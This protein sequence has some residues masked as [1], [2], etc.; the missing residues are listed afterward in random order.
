MPRQ[1]GL[2]VFRGLLDHLATLTRNQI[3]YHG[4]NIE[5][6]KLADPTP[7]SAARSTYSIARSPS[8]SPRSQNNLPPKP[9]NPQVNPRILL[10]H[11]P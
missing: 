4:T 6:D 1:L 2:A 8:P 9:A 5:I 3:R 11:V 10:F 7:S